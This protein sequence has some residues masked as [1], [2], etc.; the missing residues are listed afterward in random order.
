MLIC[1]PESRI[2]S[3]LSNNNYIEIK[4]LRKS[5]KMTFKE[6]VNS[7]PNSTVEIN[8]YKT[9]KKSSNGGLSWGEIIAIILPIVAVLAIITA[10]IFLIKHKSTIAPPV[11]QIYRVP[12]TSSPDI[13]AYK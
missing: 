11:E 6:G 12:N 10:L 9:Y 3:D 7:I 8:P 5:L 2:N 4:D 13:N 1:K